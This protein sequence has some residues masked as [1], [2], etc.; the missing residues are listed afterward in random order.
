MPRASTMTRATS[1]GLYVTRDGLYA[2]MTRHQLSRKMSLSLVAKRKKRASGSRVP[3]R[4]FQ[5]MSLQPSCY[6]IVPAISSRFSIKY[7]YSKA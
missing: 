2:A 4:E 1:L 3:K 6:D 5:F 7:I